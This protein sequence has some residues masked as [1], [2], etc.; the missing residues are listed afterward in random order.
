V[1]LKISLVE[2][3]LQL[4]PL[5]QQNESDDVVL[6]LKTGLPSATAV[7]EHVSQLVHGVERED[8]RQPTKILKHPSRLLEGESAS[9]PFGCLFASQ[10]KR[11][12]GLGRLFVA[13][14]QDRILDTQPIPSWDP[15]T[16]HAHTEELQGCSRACWKG[17]LE[18]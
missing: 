14:R 6:Q 15:Y 17:K 18:R 8:E 10:R 3:L 9:D 1:E 4:Q 7:N 2:E 5:L 12:K 11:E 13:Y 16:S